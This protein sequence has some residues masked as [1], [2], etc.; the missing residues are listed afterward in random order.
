MERDLETTYMGRDLPDGWVVW[1]DEDGVVICYK[2]D[3]FNADEYP[4]PCLPLV[5]VTK[6]DSGTV[7]GREGWRVTFHMEA[8]VK[9]YELQQVV[10]GYEDAV[11]Y[12]IEVAE[13]FSAGEYD[14]RDFYAEGDVR[15]EYVRRVERETQG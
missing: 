12:M 4:R 10:I 7:G 9:S 13:D 14:L 5:T 3:V 15:E 8:D 2:P 1:S 6:A 11:D